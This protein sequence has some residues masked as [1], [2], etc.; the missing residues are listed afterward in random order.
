MYQRIDDV[1]LIAEKECIETSIITIFQD[2][3]G[4]TLEE[5]EVEDISNYLH[6]LVDKKAEEFLNMRFNVGDEDTVYTRIC[7]F[8]ELKYYRLVTSEQQKEF[9]ELRKAA[10]SA[11]NIFLY[12]KKLENF[13]RDNKIRFDMDRPTDSLPQNPIIEVDVDDVIF[14]WE[15]AEGNDD[16]E[17]LR[18]RVLN[19]E[20]NRRF[21]YS[22]NLI[23]YLNESSIRYAVVLR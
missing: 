22:E 10:N 16:T 1:M 19:N 2:L 13:L 6:D 3:Y 9:D 8:D 20:S 23:D 15:T 17:W 5:W 12:D 14:L 21:R 7:I 11:L 18:E 4:S